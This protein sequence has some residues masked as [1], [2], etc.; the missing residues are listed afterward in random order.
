MGGKQNMGCSY[1]VFFVFYTQGV[2]RC[3]LEQCGN[4][5]IATCLKCKKTAHWYFAG[6]SMDEFKSATGSYTCLSYL[7]KLNEFKMADISDCVNVDEDQ[8]DHRMLTL[9]RLQVYYFGNRLPFGNQPFTESY[10]WD[11]VREISILPVP[12]ELHNYAGG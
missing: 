1:S 2:L 5:Q 8:S 3:L 10:P 7:K 9:T 12:P 6:V 4:G 11:S